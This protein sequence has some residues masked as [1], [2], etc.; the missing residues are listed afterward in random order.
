MSLISEGMD[1]AAH[2]MEVAQGKAL[3]VKL[4]RH[5]VPYA[6]LTFLMHA[7]ANLQNSKHV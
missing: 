4:V 6:P 3:N 7:F 2:I 1:M 5:N